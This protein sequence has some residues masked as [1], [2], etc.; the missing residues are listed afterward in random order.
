MG[1]DGETEIDLST[2]DASAGKAF[3][4]SWCVSKDFFNV[5]VLGLSFHFII[6]AFLCTQV[7]SGS[8]VL[9]I[10]SCWPCC[11]SMSSIFLCFTPCIHQNVQTQVHAD[12]GFA[13]LG[14]L[15]TALAIGALISTPII[16]FIGEK[17]VLVDASD[18]NFY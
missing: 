16:E 8:S 15:Y 10:G 14:I 4:K 5:L 12:L 17:Y 13:T 1:V 9:T 3:G 6:L 2:S 18:H 7:R 11:G